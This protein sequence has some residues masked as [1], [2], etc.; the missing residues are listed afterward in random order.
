MSELAALCR[1]LAERA[2][3]AA[4]DL[5][6]ATRA[7]GPLA[8]PVGPDPARPPGRPRRRQPPRRR[9]R[10]RPR[11]VGRP[12]RPADAHPGPAHAGAD[13]LRQVAALPDPVGEVR[14]GGVRPNGLEVHKV[15]VP[16]GRRSSS[17]TSRG[18]TSRSTP[19]P[20]ASRAATPSSSAAARRRSTPTRALHRRP[21]PT[22]WPTSRP[23]GRR[24]A[25][26]ADHRPRGRRPP[27]E[28]AASYID[29]AI[30]R[31]GEGLIRRVAAEATMPVLK[32]YHGNCHVYVDARRRPRTWP[33]G[34]W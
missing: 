25:A 22:R 13:G 31:G 20:C 27:A 10:P 11:P 2:R 15:G 14:E 6:L 32:H 28:A 9:G 33:S 4:A 19:P 8:P 34:S 24:R 29:L 26:G 1:N 7:E 17:S 23:A 30:P 18:R 12:D 3:A 5:A 16:L 21:A